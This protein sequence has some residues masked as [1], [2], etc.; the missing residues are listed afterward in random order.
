[1]R[2]ALNEVNVWSLFLVTSFIYSVLETYKISSVIA[3]ALIMS[4]QNE[5]SQYDGDEWEDVGYWKDSTREP[6]PPLQGHRLQSPG[7]RMSQRL[8]EHKTDPDAS[9]RD[10]VSSNHPTDTSF[11]AYHWCLSPGSPRGDGPSYGDEYTREGLTHQAH[12]GCSNNFELAYHCQAKEAMRHIEKDRRKLP[13][14]PRAP[15]S[16]AHGD[17]PR[18]RDTSFLRVRYNNRRRPSD[19]TYEQEADWESSDRGNPLPTRR[20]RTPTPPPRA[21]LPP[22]L[23]ASTKRNSSSQSTDTPQ[24]RVH[25]AGDT[26]ASNADDLSDR[27][28][29]RGGNSR[30]YES[31]SSLHSPYT[32]SKERKRRPQRS[33]TS[34]SL[35]DERPTVLP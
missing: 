35:D 18:V 3:S 23:D 1:M 11:H 26:L 6:D 17:S 15:S 20:F 2:Q 12:P 31:P 7:A 13:I 25:F 10:T 4:H 14:R 5:P 22:R 32:L 21:Y 9:Q 34:S 19:A 30:S 33:D 8:Y 16:P 27:P 29:S 24:R 28:A